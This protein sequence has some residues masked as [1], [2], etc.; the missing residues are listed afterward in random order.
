MPTRKK[1]VSAP[2]RRKQ[3]LAVAQ[4]LFAHQGF[5]ATTT[6]EIAEK[7]GMNEAILFRHFRTK[8][9]L[10][11]SV[12]DELMRSLNSKQELQKVIIGRELKSGAGPEDDEAFFASIAQGMLDRSRRE[13][14]LGRLLYFS[15]LERHS[16]SGRFF[17]TYVVVYWELLAKYIRRRMRSGDFRSFNPSL[18]ARSFIGMVGHYILM[19]GLFEAR[20]YQDFDDRLVCRTLARIW[21]GGMLAK[22]RAPRRKTK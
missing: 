10:Y 3:I 21:L 7:A 9:D 5:R 6:R 19:Q 1:R 4:K 12:L 2:D 13:P 14:N 16:L 8:E 17:R 18:A 15:A 11:W 22:S 20:K